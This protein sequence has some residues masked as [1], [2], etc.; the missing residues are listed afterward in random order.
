MNCQRMVHKG[1]PQGGVLLPLL[2][3]LAVKSLLRGLEYIG[4]DAIVYAENMALLDWTD[5]VILDYL[6]TPLRPIR[7][8]SQGDIRFLPIPFLASAEPGQKLNGGHVRQHVLFTAVVGRSEADF[9]PRIM[10]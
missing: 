2:W 5:V 9:R 3:N 8:F 10:R 6:S 4:N 1:T 7:C